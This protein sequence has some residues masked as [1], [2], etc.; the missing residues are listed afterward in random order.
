MVYSILAIALL[1]M[2]FILFFTTFQKR[3][4]KLLLEKVQREREFEEELVKTQS[5]IQEQTLKNIGQELHDNVGQLL[6][7]ANMQLSLVASLTKDTVKTKVDET[8]EVISDVIR[9]VRG[10]S[11]VLNSEAIL[12]FGLQES[13]QNEIDRLNRL[14]SIDATLTIEGEE[15]ELHNKDAIIL[16][17]I[18]QEFLSNTIKYAKA[19]NFDVNLKY[20]EDSLIIIAK[21]DGKGFDVDK[22]KKGSGLI[23]M[24]NRAM[25]INTK[26]TLKSQLNE[27]TEL[28]L[29]YP[30]TKINQTT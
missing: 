18:L 16:F 3:K 5:E 21:E 12:N 9:E 13:I 11:K 30:I 1:V 29:I 4:N 8:K 28:E 10:L 6:A 20:L 26:Y 23:N 24:K 2:M 19:Q 14:K 25:L 22:I 17:R 15:R 27:G 7:V